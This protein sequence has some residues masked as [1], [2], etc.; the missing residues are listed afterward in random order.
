MAGM[1]KSTR[2]QVAVL[3]GTFDPPHLGHLA[4][5]SMALAQL[6]LL[7]VLFV[8]TADPPHKQDRQ[9]SPVHIRL[10]MLKAAIAD[11]PA[12]AVSRVEIDRA[13]PHYA[14]DTMKLLKEKYPGM[15]IVYLIGADSLQELPT[16]HRPA[17]FLESISTLGVMRRPGSSPELDELKDKLPELEAK[18]KFIETPL[19]DISSRRIRQRAREGGTFRYYLPEKVFEYIQENRVYQ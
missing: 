8:L 15:E 12:F 18:L 11:Q 7:E 1:S 9:I 2:G 4:L 19:L 13:G 6:G 14:L 5:A 17:D 3:G 16:W 10:A